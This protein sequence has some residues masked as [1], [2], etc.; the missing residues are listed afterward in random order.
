M[1]TNCVV[2]GGGTEELV[3]GRQTIVVGG[4]TVLG[5]MAELVAVIT[6]LDAHVPPSTELVTWLSTSGVRVTGTYQNIVRLL[7]STPK[8]AKAKEARDMK[9][10]PRKS[11]KITK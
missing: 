2:G 4:I 7:T 3:V 11:K 10:Q 5:V 6:S 9:N 1:V 8:L